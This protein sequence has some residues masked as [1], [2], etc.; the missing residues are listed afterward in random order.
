MDQKSANSNIRSVRA[1]RRRRA[2][3][4]RRRIV[5]LIARFVLRQKTEPAP[6]IVLS[7]TG[8]ELKNLKQLVAHTARLSGISER[9]I[10]RWYYS[11]LRNGFAGLRDKQRSDAGESKS[12]ASRGLAACFALDKRADGWNTR[13]ICNGLAMLWPR[14]YND[15]S[16]PPCYRSVRRFLLRVQP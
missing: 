1:G 13:Q 9:S 2:F 12:F 8:T 4:T 6:V 14:I 7:N 5:L 3:S 16:R 10:V 11:F 15:G